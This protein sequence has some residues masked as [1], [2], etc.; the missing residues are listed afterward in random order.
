MSEETNI[1]ETVLS[2]TL[3]ALALYDQTGDGPSVVACHL[4]AA[5]DAVLGAMPMQEGNEL[6]DRFG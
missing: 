2:L 1:V 3:R 4:Q 6:D 5:I